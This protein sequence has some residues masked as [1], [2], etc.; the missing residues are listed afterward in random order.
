M[1]VLFTGATGFIGKYIYKRLLLE[2]LELHLIS[3]VCQDSLKNF[4]VLDILNYGEM[5]RIIKEIKP[6][7]LIHFAWDVSHGEFWNSTKNID[8]ATST[9][10]LFKL[11]FENGGKKVI[12]AGTSA[13]YPT[14]NQSVQEG[15]AVDISKLT[16]YG[17]SKR[18]AL[19]WLQK[20]NCDFMWL[21]I[22][23]IYGLGENKD[24]F[25]PLIFNA[26]K[27]G[28]QLHIDHHDTFLDYVHADDIAKFV[29]FCLK[30]KGIGAVNIGTGESMALIDIYKTVESYMR[31]GIFKL[32][33]TYRVPS[34]QSRIPDCTR[35][36]SMGFN[37]EL[38]SGFHDQLRII[39]DVS[40]KTYH[41]SI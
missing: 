35:L 18:K 2:D 5:Q 21:R 25:F 36:K 7:V 27:T 15:M 11:F 37:F 28:T 13:E 12:A 1:I 3:R 32:F 41:G 38:V 6:E 40:K 17:C 39:G 10:N 29:V 20:Y 33:K 26:V 19:E 23:G 8:Y 22:F 30:N 24:R 16:P 4:H 34:P 9:I 31:S 14:S